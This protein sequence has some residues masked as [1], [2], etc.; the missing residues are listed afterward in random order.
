M[1]LIIFTKIDI[2]FRTMDLGV[3]WTYFF[4]P[5][6]QEKSLKNNRGTPLAHP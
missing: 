5:L 1:L 2:V 3:N 6:T 4:A